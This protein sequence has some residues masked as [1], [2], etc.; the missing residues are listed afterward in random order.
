MTQINITVDCGE[1]HLDIFGMY[2]L[3]IEGFQIN[4][5]IAENDLN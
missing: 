3:D 1:K 5:A 4:Y 2:K